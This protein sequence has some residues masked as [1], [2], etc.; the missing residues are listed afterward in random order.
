MFDR[1]LVDQD[2]SLNASN[3][4][5]LSASAFFHAY[6]RVYSPVTFPKKYDPEGRFVRRYLPVLARMPKQYI[7]EPWQAPLTVQKEAGCR[8]GHDYPEP[9]VNHSQ[10]KDRNLERMRQAFAHQR[11]SVVQ[12]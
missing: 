12:W 4:L 9:I 2:W 10:V 8:V 5:W 6:H 11:S 3:W 7:Y 1:L